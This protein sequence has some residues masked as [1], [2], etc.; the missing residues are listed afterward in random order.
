MEFSIVKADSETRD[1]IVLL[2]LRRIEARAR[3]PGRLRGLP[4]QPPLLARA[5]SAPLC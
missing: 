4:T 2:S 1:Q 3:P 5:Y